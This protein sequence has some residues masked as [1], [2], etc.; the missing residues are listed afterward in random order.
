MPLTKAVIDMAKSLSNANP[1]LTKEL[2]P[3]LVSCN[4]ILCMEDISLN[5]VQDAEVE[6]NES[7]DSPGED[8]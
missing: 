5:E 1:N 8:M 2:L 7:I 6:E 4:Y 3:V